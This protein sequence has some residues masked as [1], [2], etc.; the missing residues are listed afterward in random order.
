MLAC[1]ICGQ[2]AHLPCLLQKLDL[3]VTDRPSF[4]DIDQMINPFGLKNLQYICAPCCETTIPGFYTEDYMPPS[5]PTAV[6]EES[7]HLVPEQYSKTATQSINLTVEK[8]EDGKLKSVCK[9]Y[10]QGTCKHGKKGA[11]CKYSHPPLCRKLLQ[12]RNNGSHGC[13][14]HKDDCNYHHPD[15]CKNSISRGFCY[16]KI[17]RKYHVQGTK[18]VRDSKKKADIKPIKRNNRANVNKSNEN[19]SAN[20]HENDIHPDFLDYLK[21]MKEEIVKEMDKK[22]YSLWFPPLPQ[23]PNLYQRLPMRQPPGLQQMVPQNLL[24]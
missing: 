7:A 9:F 22:L 24:S 15:M 14:L 17:C 8:G 13:K 23:A 3:E 2:E 12:H 20:N 18:R 16:K 21:K 4:K 19:E 5:E 6:T 10:S 1:A 11:A